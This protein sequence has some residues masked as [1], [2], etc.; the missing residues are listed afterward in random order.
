MKYEILDKARRDI[1]PKLAF[2]KKDFYLAGG[3]GLALQYG[4]RDSLDFDFFCPKPFDTV[5]LY[6]RITDIFVGHCL[7]KIQE[8]KNTLTILIDNKIK[9]SF[10]SYP[11]KLIAKTTSDQYLRVA[12]VLDIACMKLSAIISRATNKDYLDLYFILHQHRLEELL[13]MAAK[14]FPDLDRQ[15]ILKSL[16]Y[17]SDITKEPIK[18][19]TTKVAWNEVEKFLNKAV[20]KL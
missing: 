6:Q 11:Y 20:N 7:K 13:K 18:Y 4:H 12:S 5:K 3:T 19:K 1:L 2:F 9:V 15:L 8:E 10:F 17:F 14:K 16:V